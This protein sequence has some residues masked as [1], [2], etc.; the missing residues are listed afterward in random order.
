MIRQVFK[1]SY[2][3]RGE[4]VRADTV[5]IHYI[6]N[7]KISVI[8]TKMVY[9]LKDEHEYENIHLEV[10]INHKR[11]HAGHSSSVEYAMKRLQKAMPEGNEIAC[12]QSCRHG[13]FNPYG[14]LDNEIYCLAGT[15]PRNR[16]DVVEIFSGQDPSLDARKRKLFDFCPAYR[17]VDDSGLY[18]YNDWL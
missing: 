17:P 18:T 16:A 14:D 13:N 5:N 8:P 15:S 3:K 4:T 10:S 11:I 7:G 12:C 9:E 6:I 1:D 2:H